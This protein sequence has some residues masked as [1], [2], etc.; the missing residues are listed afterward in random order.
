[1]NGLT[2]SAKTDIPPVL[3]YKFQINIVILRQAGKGL[4]MQDILGEWIVKL[5]QVRYSYYNK[6]YISHNYCNIT[7][8]WQRV[9][10]ARHTW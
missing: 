5:S 3:K 2:I 6:K 10:K 9:G 1:V 8:G 7:P 4:A